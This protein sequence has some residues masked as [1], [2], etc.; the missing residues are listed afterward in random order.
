MARLLAE[1][2]G[3][4]YLD[5]GAMYRAVALK[6]V[7][8]KLDRQ[9]EAALAALLQETD[10]Q[11]ELGPAGQKV[12]LDGQDVTADLRTAELSLAASEISSHPAVRH[13]LVQLQR[14]IAASRDLV[15][16][17]RDIGSYVLPEARFK[18]Y[19]NADPEERARRRLLDLRAQGDQTTGLAELLEQINQR[20]EQDKNRQLAPLVQAADAILIDSTRLSIDQVIELLLEHIQKERPK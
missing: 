9:D 16:E 15:L 4:L 7:R 20:D 12:L 2:L 18:F 8:K 1:R 19:L 6:A 17:G 3:I 10:L 11:V 14:Q 13:H 5:T